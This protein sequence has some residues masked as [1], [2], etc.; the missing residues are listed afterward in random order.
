MSALTFSTI[1]FGEDVEKFQYTSNV[2]VHDNQDDFIMLEISPEVY[3]SMNLRFKDLRLYHKEQELDYLAFPQGN[4]QMNNEENK[5]DI[6]NKGTIGNIYSFEIM[7]PKDMHVG[8]IQ[9]SVKLNASQYLLKAKIYGSND[10]RE[11]KYLTT[12]T[13]YGIDGQ[14]NRFPLEN[15]QY[16]VIK[17]EYELLDQGDMLEVNSVVYTQTEPILNKGA[18]QAVGY[19]SKET[20]EQKAT[21]IVIDHLYNHYPTS[22]LI[23]ESEEK[24]FY[25][26]VTVSGSNDKENWTEITRTY[27][28]RDAVSAKLDIN[29]SPREYRYLRMM[30][31][32][33]DNQPL[34]INRIKT[35]VLPLYVLVNVSNVPRDFT[36]KAFWGNP[37]LSAPKYDITN[38]NITLDSQLYKQY[39]I[40]S[41]MENK[42]FMGV[43]NQLPLTERFPWLMP[44][45]LSLLSIGVLVF[46]Y[47]TVKQV[48]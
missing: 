8:D 22:G 41:Y 3:A 45:S 19:T 4:Q 34:K 27:I 43:V 25:R 48:G 37:S 15:I 18:L 36:I 35:E 47:K 31:E 30:I 28:Y 20:I 33:E 7:P 5:L 17:I 32:N 24:Y 6:F 38:L 9:Y 1:A 29:Y 16:D 39:G 42:E 26:Q 46:L 10:R 12:Q 23:L 13:I 44:A 11:W 14:Y 2:E 21:E 40:Y